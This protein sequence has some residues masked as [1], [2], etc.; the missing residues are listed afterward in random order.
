MCCNKPKP[1]I[2]FVIRKVSEVNRVVTK[3]PAFYN[4]PLLGDVLMAVQL[5]DSQQCDVTPKFVDKKGN[6]AKVDGAPT[7]LTDNPDVLS[8]TP[9]AD[10]LTC[11]VAAVGPLG[12]GKISMKADADLGAGVVELVGTLDFEITAGQATTV[13]LDVGAATEQP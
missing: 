13:I 5:T 10:G 8:L 1:R 7:W 6:P 2:V 3:T 12:A 9:S 4:W 11:T